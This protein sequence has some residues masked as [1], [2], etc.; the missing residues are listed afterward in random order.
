MEFLLWLGGVT[1]I[2]ML[3]AN[4]YAFYREKSNKKAH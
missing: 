2:V 1:I 3:V 4:A